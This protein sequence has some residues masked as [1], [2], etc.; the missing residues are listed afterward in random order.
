[1]GGHAV[2][3]VGYDDS[4]SRF[5]VRNSWGDQWAKSGYFEMPYE[6]LLNSDLSDDFWRIRT[7]K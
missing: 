5:I 7:I 6:Y 2:L 4:T 1:L 3:V